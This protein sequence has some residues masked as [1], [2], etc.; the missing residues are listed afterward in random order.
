VVYDGVGFDGKWDGVCV[1][2][3][4]RE[5]VLDCWDHCVWVV[6]LYYVSADQAWYYAGYVCQLRQDASA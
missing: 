3:T 2:K 1:V 6:C 5:A 4:G